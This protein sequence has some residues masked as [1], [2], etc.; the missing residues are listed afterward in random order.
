MAIVPFYTDNG[1][2]FIKSPSVTENEFNGIVT[3]FS[4]NPGTRDVDVSHTFAD[5]FINEQRPELAEVSM[6]VV[7]SGGD[8]P[9]Y[10]LG[11]S[12]TDT[13]P[14]V[15]TGDST[16]VRPIIKYL[17]YDRDQLAQKMWVFS[18]VYNTELSESNTTD[19]ATTWDLTFKTT[20]ALTSYHWTP[21]A[22]GS[23]LLTPI[24]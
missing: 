8:L 22:A 10:I 14:R 20:A 19:E 16:R 3:D 18:G 12:G 23:P 7:A 24:P 2:V 6:T 21:D 9:L 17:Q 1:S 4:V 15:Y 11:G 5:S 13:Y